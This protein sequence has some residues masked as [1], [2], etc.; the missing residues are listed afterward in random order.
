MRFF[1]VRNLRPAD[2]SR[3]NIVDRT[4]WVYPSPVPVATGLR[5]PWTRARDSVP[6][7]YTP[8]ELLYRSVGDELMPKSALIAG[9]KLRSHAQGRA[10]FASR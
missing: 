8:F 5:F 2:F 7:Y 4:L 3:L 10:Q 1:D 9:G 6:A